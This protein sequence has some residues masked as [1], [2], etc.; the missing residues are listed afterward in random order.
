[1]SGLNIKLPSD[2]EKFLESPIKTSSVLETHDPLTAISE[3]KKIFAKNK[4]LK[5]EKNL[6]YALE[7]DSKN[8]ASNWLNT[9]PLSRYNFNLNISELREVIFL[10]YEWERTIIPLT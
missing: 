2:C 6:K 4:T 10:R 7:L 5:T 9:L 1:M 3:Q 8:G